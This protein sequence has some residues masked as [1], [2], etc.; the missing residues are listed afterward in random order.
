MSSEDKIDPFNIV[1]EI[2]WTFLKSR[3]EIEPER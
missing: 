2:K 1:Q 3:D